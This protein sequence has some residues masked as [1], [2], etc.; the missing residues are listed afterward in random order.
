MSAGC[1][2]LHNAFGPGC[3]HCAP[4]SQMTGRLTGVCS[5]CGTVFWADEGHACGREAA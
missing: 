1:S 5:D 4:R 2:H 3:P